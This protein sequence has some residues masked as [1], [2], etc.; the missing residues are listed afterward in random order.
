[1]QCNTQTSLAQ[2]RAISASSSLPTVP[3][4]HGRI[5]PRTLP[6]GSFRRRSAGNLNPPQRRSLHKGAAG[7]RVHLIFVSVGVLP[8]LV[9]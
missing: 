1:M 8:P 2:C 4:P 5:S 7:H 6:R 3:A 9:H